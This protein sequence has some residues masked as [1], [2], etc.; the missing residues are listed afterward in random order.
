MVQIP[1]FVRVTQKFHHEKIPDVAGEV[2]AQLQRS[3]V[4]IA[5]G[6]RIAIAVGSR[7][8]AQLPVIVRNVVTWVRAQGGIPFLVPAMGSH[9]NGEA[10]AQTQILEGLGITE[11]TVGA[12]VYSSMEVVE[13]PGDGLENHVYMDRYAY[14]AD[15][16]IVINRIKIHGDFSG[17]TESGLL[18]MCVIGLGKHAQALEIHQFDISRLREMIV[19]TARQVIR[20]GNLILGVGVVEN[21]YHEPMMIRAILPER[22]EE[23]EIRMLRRYKEIMPQLPVR[24][25]DILIVDE[26]GKE[27]SGAGMETKIVGRLRSGAPEP[28]FPK[29]RYIVTTDLTDASHGNACGVG[30]ADF[31]TRRLFDKIDLDATNE[32][33]I[34]CRCVEQGRIPIIAKDDRQA[35]EYDIRSLGKL[36]HNGPRMIRIK[37]TLHMEDLYVT[38]NLL[39]EIQACAAVQSIGN[40]AFPLFEGDAGKMKDFWSQPCD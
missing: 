25:F 34:T 2:M 32:N 8:I 5:P 35:V 21:A 33:I 12:P 11:V 38:P 18:K 14:E 39:P 4:K 6:S 27:I 13:L 23:E 19:H 9:G 31:I 28:E 20:H 30:I 40:V 22:F 15:G 37:N 3:G 16:T 10:K 7:G 29:I 36:S 17:E 24:T 26:I 1:P